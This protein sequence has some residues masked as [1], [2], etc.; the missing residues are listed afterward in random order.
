VCVR[1]TALYVTTPYA[2][3][4]FSQETVLSTTDSGD[5]QETQDYGNK[6]KGS[7]KRTG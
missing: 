4:A 2:E 6:V 3:S 1:D 5:S 7:Y